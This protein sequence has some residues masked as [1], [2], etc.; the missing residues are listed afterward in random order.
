MNIKYFSLFCLLTLLVSGTSNA[1][2][3]QH[4]KPWVFW[5]WIKGGYSKEGITAD[6]EAMKQAGIGGAYL[7]PIQGIPNPPLYTPSTAQLSPRWWELVK[8]SLTEADRLGLKIGMHVSD[9]FALAGGPWI[10][11]ELSMQKVVS[12]RINVT[13]GSKAKIILPK[14]EITEN[15]YKDIAVYAFP[16]AIGAGSSTRT[17]I[18]KVTTSNGIKADSLVLQAQKEAFRSNDPAYIQYAFDKPFT[19][20]TVLIHTNG[21]NVQA[22]RLIIE[23]SDDGQ[24]WKKVTR[25]EPPRHGWQDTDEDVTHSI[26]T[27]TAKY[28]RFT[29]N[30]EGS[31]PGAEDLDNAKWKP[32]LK[33]VR[34]ELFS[35]AAIHQFEGK[36]GAIWR[37]SKRADDALISKNLCIPLSKIINL[38]GRLN[39]D[40]SLNWTAPKGNWTILRVGHTSTGHKNETA[41]AGKGLE[42]DK[43]NPEAIKLQFNGWYGEALKQAGPELTP[44]VLNTFHVD[45]WE[46][47]SQN[48]SPVFRDEFVK[49]RGYDPLTYL[50]A[51]AGIPVEDISTSEKFLYDI[52]KT[53]AELVVDKFYTTLAALAKEKGV[54]FSAESIAPTMMSDGL[55]H[56]KHSDLPMGEFWLNSPT[57]DKP[58]DMLDAISGAH[59]YGK[60]IIQAE[61]FTTVRMT[62][63][64]HPGM[65]KTLQ[66]RNYA[67]GINKLV[68]HVFTHNPWLDRKPGMT[69]DGV[70]LYFQRDQT[71]WKPGKAW[72]EYAERCQALLQ[73]GKPVVDIAVFTGEELPRRSVLPERLVPVLPGLFGKDVVQAEAKRLANEGQPMRQQPA[74]VSNSANMADAEDF[75]NPLRGYAY[76]SFNPDVFSTAKVVNGA[77]VFESGASYKLIVIPGKLALNPNS[78]Y[79]S[80]AVAKKILDLLKEGA[81]IQLMEKPVE[82]PGLQAGAADEF[83]NVVNEIWNGKYKGKLIKGAYQDETLDAIGLQRDVFVKEGNGSYAKNIAYTHR[84]A[85]GQ[86]I[87]FISNQE[88]KERILDFSFRNAGNIIELYDAVSGDKWNATSFGKYEGDGI[89]MDLK[90]NANASLFIIFKRGD[91]SLPLKKENNWKSIATLTQINQPWKVQFDSKL[92]GPQSPVEFKQLSDWSTNQDSLIKYYSGTAIYSTTLKLKSKPAKP[93]YLDLGEVANI[94]EV[95]VNGVACGTAWTYP[96]RVDIS[97]AIKKGENQIR[98]DVTNTWANRLIGDQRLPEDKRMTK[99]TA[100]YRLEGKP[101]QAAGLLGE[102]KVLVEE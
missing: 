2:D 22:H 5:Y 64:E 94:A 69:L 15:Y 1:Q 46:C 55:L 84:K 63:S 18:P 101:L 52:R 82:Q 8:F 48:W 40:G 97:K 11:P 88:D 70:G 87:Y 57:H 79:M 83:L 13:G 66:D 61:S 65:L 37:V 93:V 7:M 38:S 45:S 58:N 81:T 6:L 24:N 16:S 20:R 85:V 41:G 67:L 60:N 27:T 68:Y 56:Y 100:P 78:Q 23:A 21:N 96:Y 90:L 53:I 72:V 95:I 102:V 74:G 99:T 59:I 32:S 43:F 73:Q 71:W 44:R 14:P 47:G 86:D 49:R 42:C 50:P 33:V 80:L 51:M 54:L 25:L 30:K 3:N 98:V 34:L 75:I 35:E 62:W 91:K 12:S 31:E 89:S 77:V 39:P 9:G 17:I 36:S 29:Y 10:T 28:F 4:T 76:D 92:G 26:P 19:A